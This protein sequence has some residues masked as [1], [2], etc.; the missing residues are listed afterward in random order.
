MIEN[1]DIVITHDSTLAP[2]GWTNP[3]WLFT[4][5]IKIGPKAFNM[6]RC[7]PCLAATLLHEVSHLYGL[8]DLSYDI[9][10][11]TNSAPALEKRCIA[12]EL[13]Q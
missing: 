11:G 6:K 4:P 13:C 5:E 8:T 9:L 2:C 12:E 3:F 10:G 7:G 1:F